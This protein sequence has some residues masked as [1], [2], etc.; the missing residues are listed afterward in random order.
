MYRK[1]H[2][3]HPE[4]EITKAIKCYSYQQN[5]ILQLCCALLVQN[6]SAL[7]VTVVVFF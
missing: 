7:D 6:Y 4:Q 2:N 3:R 5:T 1:W